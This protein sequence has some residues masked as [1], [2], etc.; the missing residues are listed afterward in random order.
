ME[1]EERFHGTDIKTGY[2]LSKEEIE[3]YLSIIISCPVIFENNYKVVNLI[4]HKIS[5]DYVK[6]NG[7]VA[8]NDPK[9]YGGFCIDGVIDFKNKIIDF[10][11]AVGKKDFGYQTI[12]FEDLISGEGK[13]K[14]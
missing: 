10:G 3:R 5:S 2:S 7:M 4:I 9:R 14:K 11:T 13:V 1:Y 8:W 12:N 6:F